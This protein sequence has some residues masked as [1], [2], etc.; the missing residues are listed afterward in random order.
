MT[1]YVQRVSLL[2]VYK[3][4]FIQQCRKGLNIIKILNVTKKNKHC[5]SEATFK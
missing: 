4:L 3:G 5:L 1:S 2:Q